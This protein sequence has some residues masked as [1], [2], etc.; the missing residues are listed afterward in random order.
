M[1][2]PAT[3]VGTCLVVGLGNRD[4]GDDAVGPEV[5]ARVARRLSR[6]A[7][8]EAGTRHGRPGV[9]VLEH[10]D[11]AALIDTWAGADLVVVVDGIRSGRCPGTIV[12]LEAGADAAPLPVQP[13]SAPGRGGTHALGLAAVV[14]LA[15]A[16]D[17]LPRRLVVVGVEVSGTEHGAPL[18]PAVATAVPAAANAVITL[19]ERASGSGR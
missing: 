15:R 17:R 1:S 10:E 11:P 4:R 8:R 5:A 7:S 13:W 14:E 6:R 18:C 2:T 19:L 12:L 3:S 16:L 9:R